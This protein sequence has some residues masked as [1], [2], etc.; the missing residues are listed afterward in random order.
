MSAGRVDKAVVL[1][2]GLGTR[3]RRRDASCTLARRQAAAAEAGA[4]AM[5]PMPLGRPLLDYVLSALA[6]AGYRQACLV[7]GPEHQAVR[8][9]YVRTSRPERIAVE[10]AVQEKPLGTADAVLAAQEFAAGEPFTAIN[11]DNYYPIE[12]LRALRGLTRCGL[13]AF[14]ADALIR[15]NIP[16]QRVARFAV[17]EVGQDGLLKKIHE[18]PD[19]ATMRFL[20]RPV[21]T[22]M[23]CWRFGPSIFAACRA[24]K[25]S[26]RG[27]LELTS[28]VQHA[29]DH[30]GDAF[31]A[32]RFDLPVLDLSCRRDVASMAE[33]L[34]GVEVNP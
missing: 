13:A 22:S 15:G 26:P 14:T 17:L 32:L 28:A 20:A 11:G 4:K 19:A 16:A 30:L 24:I 10:F 5:M 1:A 9:Y 12:A 29:V 7:I 34:R 33:R 18:K 6:D 27:E 8:D 21:L 25:P 31:E 23:N 3:M 2:R